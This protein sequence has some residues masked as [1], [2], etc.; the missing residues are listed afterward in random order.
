MSR[1]AKRI[2]L[3]IFDALVIIAS[4][5]CSY[6]FLYPLI[7]ISI[8][9]FIVHVVLVTLSYVILCYFV[10]MFDKINRFTSIR[11]TINYNLLVTLSFV[12][13]MLFYTVIADVIS[14]RYVLAAFI[15]SVISIP[16]SRIVWRLWIEHQRKLQ[17]NEYTALDPVRTL[18]IGAGDGGAMYVNGLR[19]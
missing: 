11:E 2:T 18:L 7:E 13:G 12:I 10:K 19:N 4:H 6:F 14:F 9:T 8:R 1:N 3:M 15:L 16:A 5:I 17:N